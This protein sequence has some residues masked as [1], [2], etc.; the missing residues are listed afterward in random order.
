[1]CLQLNVC[2]AYA[3]FPAIGD[4]AQRNTTQ[5]TIMQRA[6]TQHCAQRKNSVTQRNVSAITALRK[7]PQ[8]NRN[9]FYFFHSPQGR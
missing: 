8:A 1:M 9:E 5:R 3:R 2:C 4:A 7:C 6:I